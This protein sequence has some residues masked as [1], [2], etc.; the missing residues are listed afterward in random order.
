M[1]SKYN[2]N[3]NDFLNSSRNVRDIVPINVSCSNMYSMF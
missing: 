1:F 2:V 3:S